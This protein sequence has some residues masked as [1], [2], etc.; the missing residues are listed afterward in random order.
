VVTLRTAHVAL[1]KRIFRLNQCTFWI[2]LNSWQRGGSYN[3]GQVDRAGEA[4]RKAETVNQRGRHFDAFL[5]YN[6][7]R[8]LMKGHQLKEAKEHLDWIYGAAY[9]NRTDT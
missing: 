8:L 3:R 5:D 2:V 6:Y 1:S 7:G 9:R 4:Y